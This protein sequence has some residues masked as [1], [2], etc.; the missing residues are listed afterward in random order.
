MWSV[1]GLG[2]AKAREKPGPRTFRME[3]T[4]AVTQPISHPPEK[5]TEAQVRWQVSV[6]GP[7]LQFPL[8]EAAQGCHP[9][10]VSTHTETGPFSPLG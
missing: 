1:E 2:G 10:C 7:H 6:T 8:P 5:E 4:L 3:G 9:L